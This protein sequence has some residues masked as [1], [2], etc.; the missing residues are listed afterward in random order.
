M[1]LFTLFY[2]YETSFTHKL[3]RPV[4]TAREENKTKIHKI[5]NPYHKT[6][7]LCFGLTEI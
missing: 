4:H 1:H 7:N 2:A 6:I 3:G 5:C